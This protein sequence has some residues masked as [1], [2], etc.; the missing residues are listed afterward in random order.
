M[1][2]PFLGEMKMVG[3]NFPPRGWALCEGQMLAI[4][5][6]QALFSLLGTIY[7]G[8]GVSTFALPDMRGR[9]GIGVSDRHPPGNSAG[10]EGH[11]LSVNEMPAHGHSASCIAAAGTDFTPK[12][13]VWAQDSG[14]N[15]MFAGKPAGTLA[16]GAIAV[17]GGGHPHENMQPYLVVNWIIAMEGIFPPRS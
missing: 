12:S 9:I 3:F 6:N 16:S 4:N 2:E 5:Q 15:N 10:E 8:D 7:G 14:G 13:N 1:S 17:A 11:T